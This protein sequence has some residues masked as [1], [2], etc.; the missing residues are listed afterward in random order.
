MNRTACGMTSDVLWRSGMF[1][2]ILNL[3]SLDRSYGHS[4]ILRT[5]NHYCCY[6]G[7]NKHTILVSATTHHVLPYKAYVVLRTE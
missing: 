6:Y 2:V 1:R 5:R 7:A 3:L 4:V